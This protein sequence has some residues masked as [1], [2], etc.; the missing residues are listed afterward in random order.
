MELSIAEIRH[1]L[2]TAD[3]QGFEA[4]AASLKSD[5]R[6][7]VVSALAHER[8]RRQ[9][10]ARE[11]ERLEGLFAYEAEL[12]AK[13][14]GSLAIGLDEVGRGPLAGPL[15]VGAVVL[16]RGLRIEGLDDSKRVPAPKRESI[17]SA[18][19]EQA[20]A[21][22]VVFIESAEIDEWGM[23]RSL[24]TAFSRSVASLEAQGID[25][26]LLLLDGNPL[27]FDKRE[28]N[29]VKGDGKCASIAAASI[30]AKV[31]RDTLMIEMDE[32]FPHYGFAQNKGYG[33]AS[34]R[35]ALRTY[36]LCDIHRKSF[37]HEFLQASL[38]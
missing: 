26:D 28:V 23:T 22:S 11:R 7:G 24:R 30:L 27:H 4:L 20:S 5:P 1:Q 32:R 36:G 14:G 15:A 33:T 35:E 19:K 9:R 12:V 21:W 6:K 8:S 38:F 37:C 16:P 10:R 17:A 34:H 31:A 13:R 3:D 25:A 2:A 29:I 18:I